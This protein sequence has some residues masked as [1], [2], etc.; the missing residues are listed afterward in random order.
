[1]HED[2]YRKLIWAY[3]ITWSILVC[4]VATQ[5]LYAAVIYTFCYFW[6]GSMVAYGPFWYIKW[7]I[8]KVWGE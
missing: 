1:M 6:V 7:G 8:N 3:I 2:D 4:C 5:G